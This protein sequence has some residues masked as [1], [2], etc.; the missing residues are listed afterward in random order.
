MSLSW[1]TSSMQQ[2]KFL[3]YERFLGIEIK[4]T[5]DVLL[6]A[7]GHLWVSPFWDE[8][9][10]EFWKGWEGEKLDSEGSFRFQESMIL[11]ITNNS[12]SQGQKWISMSSYT[13]TV[14]TFKTTAMFCICWT[15]EES[16]FTI[17]TIL[18]RLEPINNDTWSSSLEKGIVNETGAKE[19]GED[20]N[21]KWLWETEKG[22]QSESY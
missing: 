8:N 22:N 20:K 18:R 13:E 4:E 19:K 5:A 11:F 10:E 16:E 7:Q 2:M 14:Y 9:Q 6:W 17:S 15:T 21:A 12:L 3:Y 1:N